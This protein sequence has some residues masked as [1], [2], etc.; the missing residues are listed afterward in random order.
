MLGLTLILKKKKEIN[1]SNIL[2]INLMTESVLIDLYVSR[3]EYRRGSRL[4]Y[5]HRVQV[6]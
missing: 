6:V 1:I 5:G 2:Y 4:E 3:L